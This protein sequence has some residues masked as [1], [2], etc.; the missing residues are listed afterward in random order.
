MATLTDFL[1]SI[2]KTKQNVIKKSP[3]PDAAEKAYLPFV[4][5]RSLSYHR[6]VVLL[7]NEL[8][9]RGLSGHNVSN[10][11]HYEFL[12][13]AIPKG[14]RFSKWTKPEPDPVVE[15]LMQVYNYNYERAVEANGL[16]TE[17]QRQCIMEE[18]IQGG[19]L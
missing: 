12:L 6:D 13:R 2:N 14:N 19:K 8:N 10:K 5:L 7:C 4:T 18:P 9:V 15:R 1:N 3:A 16:L 11:M 17:E